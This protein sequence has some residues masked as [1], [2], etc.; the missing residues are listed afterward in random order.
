MASD[1]YAFGIIMWE[2]ATR[3]VTVRVAHCVHIKPNATETDM[4]VVCLVIALKVKDKK[5]TIIFFSP[6]QM[7]RG[8]ANQLPRHYNLCFCNG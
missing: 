5:A 6:V 2:A 7:K 4:T 8:Q 1:T 3:Q